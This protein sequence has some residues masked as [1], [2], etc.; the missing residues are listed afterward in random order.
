MSGGY[1]SVPRCFAG[2]T[3]AVLASGESMSQA[4]A[5]QV[6]A[7]DVPA[8]AINTTFR[9][10]PW[11][12]MLYAADQQWW[13]HP[14]YRDARGFAGLK[15]SCEPAAG[16]LRMENTGTTGFD[17]MPWRLRTG[18]N[19]GYQG[20]HIAVHAGA[21]RILLCGFDMHG[22]HWHPEH[23][24][25]LKQT[26]PDT[27]ERWLRRFADVAPVLERMGL[28]VVNCTP[29]SAL[30]CFRRADL[31]SELATSP[32]PAAREPALPA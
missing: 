30:T 7:A 31:E 10:A 22:G 18:G 3:V 32:E 19:G 24:H 12:W 15:V 5:D 21:R 17:P 13:D 9:L 28:D 6:R 27:Y 26:Q 2:G 4:V 1:W 8:I 20:M 14:D 23:H 11:A 16:I 29:G 25:T